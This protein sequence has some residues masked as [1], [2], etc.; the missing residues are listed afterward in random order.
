M[1]L[2]W[3]ARRGLEEDLPR[4]LIGEIAVTTDTERLF[5]GTGSGNI[6][7]TLTG[8]EIKAF[9][10]LELKAFT[11][12]LY[13]K[14][15]LLGTYTHTQGTASATWTITHN[16]GRHPSV[17]VVDSDEKTVVGDIEYISDNVIQISF[18]GGFSGKAHLN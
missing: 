11:D 3:R 18:S 15:I 7:V 10:E 6:V 13:D 8:P 12:L 1:A 14:L 16:L 4:L 9:Y 2:T 5:I 17:T